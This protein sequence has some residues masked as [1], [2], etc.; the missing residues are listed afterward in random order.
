MF[1][2]R[3]QDEKFSEE[4]EFIIQTVSEKITQFGLNYLKKKVKKYL[5]P[6][7]FR[8]YSKILLAL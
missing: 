1:S 7:E 5:E 6:Q 2:V 8:Q 4:K 3:V